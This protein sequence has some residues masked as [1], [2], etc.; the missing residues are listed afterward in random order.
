MF[1]LLFKDMKVIMLSVNVC[2]FFL[3]THYS[4]VTFLLPHHSSLLDI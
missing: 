4:V 2:V 3:N 1:L